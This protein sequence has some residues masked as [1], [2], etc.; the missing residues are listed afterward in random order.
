MGFRRSEV[1]NS[2]RP[3]EKLCRQTFANRLADTDPSTSGIQAS[4]EVSNAYRS[5]T[6][7]DDHCIHGPGY[8]VFRNRVLH[9]CEDL[10]VLDPQGNRGGPEYV[11]GDSDRVGDTGDRCDS[12][13]RDPRI[14]APPY[15]KCSR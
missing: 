10:A 9:H 15:W 11:A 13:S 6:T 5:E 14:A 3:N 4:T 2:E 7:R 12:I 8:G 1:G